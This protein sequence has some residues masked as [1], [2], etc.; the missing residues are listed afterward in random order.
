[1]DVMLCFLVKEKVKWNAK[2]NK[3]K[4]SNGGMEETE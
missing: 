4:G 2:W 3:E 1:M